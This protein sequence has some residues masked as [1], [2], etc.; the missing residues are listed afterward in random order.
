LDHHQNNYV[1]RL[2]IDV[3]VENV[4]ILATNLNVLHSYF[5]KFKQFL[6]WCVAK[7][8]DITS[9]STLFFSFKN[10]YTYINRR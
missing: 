3:V 8:L 10:K 5:N 6:D 7:F 4:N 9:N 1:E 2:A